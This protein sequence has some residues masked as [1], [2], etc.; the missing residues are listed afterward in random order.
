VPRLRPR[1]W[2]LAPGLQLP[3]IA[4][5]VLGL[6]L[7]LR[8]AWVL[9]H[10]VEPVSDFRDYQELAANIA[11]H[12]T[13]AVY[14]GLPT[15]FR[16]PGWPLLLGATYWVTGVSTQVG[17]LLCAVLSW[18]GA[19]VGGL[20]AYRLLRPPFALLAVA[21]LS[22]YPAGIVYTAVL[23]SE[24][25]AAALLTI[26]VALLLGTRIGPG[27]SLA[28]GLLVGALILTRPDYGFVAAA[29][30]FLEYLF[31][32][33]Q[34]SLAP[35]LALT[36]VGIVVVLAPWVA[37]NEA[38]FHEF[39]PTGGNGGVTFYLG[40]VAVKYTSPPLLAAA[41]P[42]TYD[43]PKR[44]DNFYWRKGLHNVRAHP[45]RWLGYDAGRLLLQHRS[46]YS[47]LLWAGPG[48]VRPVPRYGAFLYW[49]ALALLAVVG[50]AA[51]VIRRSN[52]AAWRPIVFT[53]VGV[54]LSKTLF[55]VNI[56]DRLPLTALLAVAA[57]YGA[58]RVYDLARSRWGRPSP[59]RH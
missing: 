30:V 11:R 36:A 6:G 10:H 3:R 23:G 56:R 55:I 27:R 25:L 16:S 19:V 34:V 49:W 52:W 43:H 39:I 42:E 38:R 17:T 51:I 13:Y 32:R 12:G 46:E 9:V 41:P 40:T 2:H 45:A 48:L 33:G 18:V 21:A 35:A 37:R 31:R 14:P 4:W 54:T 20:I 53:L 47:T 50:L 44:R 1:N 24:H 26:L 22:L 58:Q 59:G 28:I 8:I 5:S 57:G 7:A 29:V 15:A